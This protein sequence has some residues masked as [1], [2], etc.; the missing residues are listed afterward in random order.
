MD[1]I[2]PFTNDSVT[3]RDGEERDDTIAHFLACNV[4]HS[5][6]RMRLNKILRFIF[7]VVMKM[8]MQK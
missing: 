1:G 6:P 5:T 7:D 8:M 3:N 4:E 2:V